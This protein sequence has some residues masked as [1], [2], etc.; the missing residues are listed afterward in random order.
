MASFTPVFGY[1]QGV[2]GGDT[3]LWG[4][5]I[6]T[7]F[8]DIENDSLTRR[9]DLDFADFELQSAVIADTS[10]RFINANPSTNTV[11]LDFAASTST[12]TNHFKTVLDQNVTTVTM[13]NGPASTDI[14]GALWRIEQNG[15]G[16]YTVDL[17]G[18]EWAAGSV[19]VVTP[20]ANAV[21]LFT[22]IP[23]GGVSTVYG[24]VAGQDF[25]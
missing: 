20:T 18:I 2:V 6:N 5:F 21:D 17:S 15:T 22:I 16:G 1:Y 13:L 8:L 12:R 4:G 19:P 9:A 24:L 25:S 14:K 7:T 3:D 23:W 11:V 10:E